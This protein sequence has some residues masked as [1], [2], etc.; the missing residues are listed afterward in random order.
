MV[1][2]EL[3]ARQDNSAKHAPLAVDV[4]GGRI[5]DAIGPELHWM[6]KERRGEDVVDHKGRA[7]PMHD[8]S[9]SGDIDELE[10]R[11]GR[12]IRGT[13]SWCSDAGRARGGSRSAPIDKGRGD[14]EARQQFLD[15]VAHEPNKA[16]AATM[17]SPALS[18]HQGEAVTAAMPLAVARA[19]SAP[20][21]SAIRCVEHRSRIGET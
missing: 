14:P 3:F 11:I 19:A 4:F 6:L 8:L 10:R 7:R 1:G 13:P 17:W 20:S 18:S 5:D 15:H 16:R 2:D 12:R 9:N 21:S